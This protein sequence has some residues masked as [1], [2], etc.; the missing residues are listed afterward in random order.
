MVTFQ[1]CSKAHVLCLHLN[2]PLFSS[3][4]KQSWNVLTNLSKT[5]KY[6]ISLKSVQ[7]F[8]CYIRTDRRTER[9]G[10]ASWYTLN[11]FSL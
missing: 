1:M 6:K 8:S 10:E 9:Q 11:N 2:F 7:S 3:D 4:F 5:L